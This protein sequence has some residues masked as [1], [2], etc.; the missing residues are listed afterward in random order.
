MNHAESFPQDR[1]N[2]PLSDDELYQQSLIPP[3]LKDE[4]IPELDD[5][6]EDTESKFKEHLEKDGL[7]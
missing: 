2:E 4:E 5:L 3:P 7:A 6:L 1:S